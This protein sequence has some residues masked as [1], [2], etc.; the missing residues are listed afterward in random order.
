MIWIIGLVDRKPFLEI[1]LSLS[2]KLT[3]AEFLELGLILED[4]DHGHDVQVGPVEPEVGEAGKR[5][6]R[7]PREARL[8]TSRPL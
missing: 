5:L 6:R 8:R 2:K 3:N 7:E 4:G 1:N